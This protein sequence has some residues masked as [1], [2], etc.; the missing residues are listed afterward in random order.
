MNPSPHAPIAARVHLPRRQTVAG[1][2]KIRLF[3]GALVSLTVAMLG[4]LFRSLRCFAVAL[5]GG[6][7]PPS[8]VS[9]RIGRVDRVRLDGTVDVRFPDATTAPSLRIELRGAADVGPG[10]L[11]V[12]MSGGVGDM[13]SHGCPHQSRG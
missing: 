3:V 8:P 11:V 1:H 10:E 6:Q 12:V 7:P 9:M 5:W 2:V 4:T 13:R